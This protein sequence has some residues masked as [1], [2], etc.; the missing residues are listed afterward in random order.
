MKQEHAER[1]NSD[2][3]VSLSPCGDWI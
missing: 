3:A 2:K 1:A